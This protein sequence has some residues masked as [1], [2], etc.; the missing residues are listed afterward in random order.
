MYTLDENG[1]VYSRY[2]KGGRGKISDEL[3]KLVPVLDNTGYFIVTLLNDVHRCNKSI[4]RLLA[5][6]YIPNP[7]NKP[8]VN[9]IDGVKTNNNLENLEWATVLENTRHAISLGLHE[10][11]TKA[12]QKSVEQIDLQTGRI[13]TTYESFAIA[14]KETGIPYPNIIKVCKGLRKHAGGYGWKYAETSETI[15]YGVGQQAN[16]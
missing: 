1:N 8:H 16:G 9:H 12:L 3:R 6:H 15:L 7:E 14:Q 4:H 2:V 10:F 5:E 11:K 13:L